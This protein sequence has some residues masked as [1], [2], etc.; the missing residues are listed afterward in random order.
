[1]VKIK[2]IPLLLFCCFITLLPSGMQ[3]Q[4]YY[5]DL[6]GVEQSNRQL[7]S[8]K[9][10]RIK[11]V[12]LQSLEPDGSP[13]P[14]FV[15]FQEC[16]PSFTSLK[17]YTTGTSTPP[18]V[19][20]SSFNYKGQLVRTADSTGSSLHVTTYAYNA[21]GLPEVAEA[22]ITG[23]SLPAPLRERHVWQFK[24]GVPVQMWNVK[25]NR[26][27][28]VV[29]FEVS[30]AGQVEEE[31]WWKNGVLQE[32]YYYY[33]DAQGRLTDLVR[34][35][36]RARRLLPDFMFEYDAEGRL[37]KLVS[38]DGRTGDYVTWT[39]TYNEKGLRSRDQCHNKQKQLVGT[40]VYTYE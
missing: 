2:I 32:R 18:S 14:G 27:T 33:Y 1:M 12:I 34:Y 31:S 40:I 8:Y 30:P 39:Y 22:L 9:T 11:K 7:K 6:V 35:N 4:Y 29:K 21:E 19:L 10:A 36:Q 13:T 38:V 26:D 17:T 5:K 28:L 20:S 24:N 15:C 37:T 23:A 16:N 3:G 25:N